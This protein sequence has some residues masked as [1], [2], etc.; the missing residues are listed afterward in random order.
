MQKGSF[1]MTFVSQFSTIWSDTCASDTTTDH[2][3]L[4]SMTSWF[5]TLIVWSPR[6]F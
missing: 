1:G 2:P 3:D 5:R 6:I 4:H